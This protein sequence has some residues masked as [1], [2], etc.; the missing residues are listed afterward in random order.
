MA[1]VD[2]GSEDSFSDGELDRWEED[3]FEGTHIVY[4][5]VTAAEF[6]SDTLRSAAPRHPDGFES[7]IEIEDTEQMVAHYRR[8]DK[9]S[10]AKED[11]SGSEVGGRLMSATLRL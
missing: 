6:N 7:A 8:K 9:L 1:G 4:E 2:D 11:L 3:N 5:C 10:R